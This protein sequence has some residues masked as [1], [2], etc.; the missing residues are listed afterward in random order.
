M[1]YLCCCLVQRKS[2]S[3]ES[4]SVNTGQSP[5]PKTLS[6]PEGVSGEDLKTLTNLRQK[7]ENN[8]LS[9]AEARALLDASG[10]VTAPLTPR[11]I[12]ELHRLL[13]TP[14]P[15]AN[16]GT[17]LLASS[18]ERALRTPT[19]HM[20]PDIQANSDLFCLPA[21]V[22]TQIWRYA[23]GGRKV[24]LCVKKGKLVQQENM[25][26]PY[27]RHVNGLLNVPLICRKSYL[28]SINL[29]YSENTFGFGFGSH[30]SCNDFFAQADELLLPQCVAA[31]TSLEVGFHLSGGYSRYYDTHP[32]A[33][34]LS[35]HI[36]APS[37][38]S[39]WNAVFKALAQM[40]QLRRLIVVVWASGD[41]RH[42]FRAREPELM[43]IPSRMMG[44]KKFDVWLP[45]K[46]EKEGLLSQHANRETKPYVV[47][48]KF[49]DRRRYGVSVPNWK[50]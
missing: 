47:L 30:G 16:S 33:W 44:L 40:K 20:L 34:D 29:L 10:K 28:E 14:P 1:D 4:N 35:L 32:Q 36:V 46:E 45:W 43:D 8:T 19:N 9:T 7:C 31:M 15:A 37:P 13:S 17:S 48:R 6:F 23:I 39:S 26:H 41:R 50:G 49:E 24:Y 2:R 21:E 18:P 27:W 38:L 3:K 5:L 42:E 12:E 25:N 11:E 22:R